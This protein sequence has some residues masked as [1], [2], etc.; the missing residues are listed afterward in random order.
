L[1]WWT[2]V[3][4]IDRDRLLRLMEFGP[5]DVERLRNASWR[6]I[7]AEAGERGSWV[8]GLLVQLL[9]LYSYNWQ[10]LASELHG[11]TQDREEIRTSRA[12]GSDE[13]LPDVLRNG[14][15][16]FLLN[17]IASGGTQALFALI[18]YLSGK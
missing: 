1:E 15:D 17:Q 8:D 9:S 11:S 6:T 4:G 3:L 18:R 13:A 10:S 14:R 16:Q 5:E 2:R 7:A 12:I